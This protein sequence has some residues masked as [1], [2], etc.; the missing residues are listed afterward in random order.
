M[1]FVHAADLHLDSPLKGLRA[2]PGAPVEAMRSATRV[3]LEALV[4]MTIEERA[5]FL[6]VA[7]DLYDGD[8]K[9]FGTGLHLGAQM[10][11]LREAGIPVLAIRGNHDAASVI[12]KRL[13]LP[14]NVHVL[15]HARPQSVVL[16]QAGAVV[17][18][19]SFATR[20]VVENLSGGYPAAVPGL[21]NV[22]LLHTSLGGYAQHERYA[23][24]AVSELVALGYDYWALGHVH[25]RAVLHERPWVVFAGNLQG[26]H[27]RECGAKGATVV[28][29]EHGEVGVQHRVLDHVRWARVEVDAAGA[30]DDVDVLERVERALGAAVAAADGRPLACRIVVSGVT[31][32]HGALVAE[33]ERLECEVRAVATD[34]GAE[35]LWVERV[36]WATTPAVQPIAG[37]DAIGDVLRIVRRAAASETTLRALAEQLKPLSVKLPPELRCDVDGLDPSDPHTLRRALGEVERMLPSLLLAGER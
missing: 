33:P 31:E 5:D 14:D 17:H 11:R 3:A 4:D 36:R 18:G 13:R 8:W 16:E 6:V 9:H 30:S 1:R 22:G 25:E 37:D 10:A 7:G 21:F 29:V 28:S 23:P 12:T 2:Y 32:A 15:D 24:C 27:A 19:Q 35:R 26:R 20:A 34:A